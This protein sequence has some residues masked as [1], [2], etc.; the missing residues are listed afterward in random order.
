MRGVP[1]REHAQWFK[2][3]LYVA[4]PLVFGYG[5]GRIPFFWERAGEVVSPGLH[6]DAVGCVC[7]GRCLHAR[8]HA[9]TRARV[10]TPSHAATHACMLSHPGSYLDMLH[11]GLS[12]PP[13][14]HARTRMQIPSAAAN[15]K[16]P[17]LKK[18]L[19]EHRPT[20]QSEFQNLALEAALDSALEEAR[21]ARRQR[22][23]RQQQQAQ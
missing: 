17:Y 20:L 21:A 10:R 14:A 19:T 1:L 15:P 11:A 5:L 16:G 7:M 3:S 12:Q 8:T 2:Y 6:V 23:A 18:E 9:P 4:V 13:R 22:E